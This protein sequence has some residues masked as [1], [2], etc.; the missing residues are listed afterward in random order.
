MLA[1]NET[2]TVSATVSNLINEEI[3][4]TVSAQISHVGTT[5]RID[6]IV[7]LKPHASQRLEWTVDSTDAVY[8]YLVLV[9]VVQLRYRDNPSMLGSCGILIFSLFGLNGPATFGLMLAVCFLALFIGATLWARVHPIFN[10]YS[11]NLA[12]A[13]M[14]LIAFTTLALL[15]TLPRWW[16]LTLLLD[17][18][19]VLM[20]GVIFTEFIL[21]PGKYKS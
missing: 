4:P 10:N 20:I 16:W 13:G 19:V 9:D 3:T 8:K 21:F 2:G 18:G 17:A 1:R 6:Q 5:R 15:S 7:S 11:F 14:V 12:R